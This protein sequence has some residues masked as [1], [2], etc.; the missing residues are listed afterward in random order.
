VLEYVA[1]L[2][3]LATHCEFGALRDRLV[4]GLR[5]SAAQ[6]SLL[7]EETLTLEK[8]IRP[9]QSLEAADKN[10]KKLKCDDAKSTCSAIH[11][12]GKYCPANPKQQ[13]KSTKLCYRCG[14]TDHIATNCRF[15]DAE[16][17]KCHTKGHLAKVCRSVE[18]YSRKTDKKELTIREPD[19]DDSEEL[20]PLHGVE[21][22]LHP[23]TVELT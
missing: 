18:D 11:K 4:C 14:D 15:R 23:I 16:C 3:R 5:S 2:R 20:S 19:S 9:A 12:A 21:G 1:E 10:T 22:K 13:P 8:A 17:K 7:S 6:K